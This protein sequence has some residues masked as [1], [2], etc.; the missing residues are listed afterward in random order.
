MISGLSTLGDL[1]IRYTTG[2]TSTG[3]SKD[4]NTAAIVGGVTLVVFTTGAH[5]GLGA[6]SRSLAPRK[7]VNI[8]EDANQKWGLPPNIKKT[9]DKLFEGSSYRSVDALPFYPA[10]L[11][12]GDKA[13]PK[14]YVKR[15]KME[16]PIMKGTVGAYRFIAIKVDAEPSSEYVRKNCNVVGDYSLNSEG[17]KEER[18][19]LLHQYYPD[20]PH[21]EGENGALLWY[22]GRG[23]SDI[24]PE[25]LEMVFTCPEDGSGPIQE[26][27]E[28]FKRVKNL[29]KN[30][31]QEDR[32]GLI[33][34]IPQT[35]GV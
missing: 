25:F 18:I 3:N 6:I 9:L 12:L 7:I 33:W 10:I 30:S 15:E 17:S 4:K 16:A 29:I 1:V 21:Q 14:N 31:V 2:P 27:K 20:G 35:G 11:D 5:Y 28:N 34:T 26:Q 13:D 19:L 32:K 22:A 23:Q 24:H 8:Q